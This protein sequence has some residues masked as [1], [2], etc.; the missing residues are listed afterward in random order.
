METRLGI[1][2]LA[3]FGREELCSGMAPA[4]NE[5]EHVCCDTFLRFRRLSLVSSHRCFS[6]T[7]ADHRYINDCRNSS[8]YNVT[9]QK[10][11]LEKKALVVAL[12]DIEEGQEIYVDYGRCVDGMGTSPP[13][14][15]FRCVIY[16]VFNTAVARSGGCRPRPCLGNEP[17]GSL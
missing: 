2:Y 4:H 16:A 11:P 6:S 14:K 8:L 10:L 13:R 7:G 15:Q 17:R 12:K 9:F 3:F 5:L 1:C